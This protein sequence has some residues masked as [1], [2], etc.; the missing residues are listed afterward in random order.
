[1]EAGSTREEVDDNRA[2]SLLKNSAGRV[3]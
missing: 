2:E 1:M 3:E